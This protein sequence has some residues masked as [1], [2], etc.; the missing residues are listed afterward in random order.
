MTAL[1]T[2]VWT[3]GSGCSSLA[4][5]LGRSRARKAEGDL[6][7]ACIDAKAD[8]L[9]ARSL[10]S[11]D[12]IDIA[13]PHHFDPENVTE[14]VAAVAGGPHSSLAARVAS[15]LAANLGVPG[16][17][18]TAS[19]TPE[20]DARA[21]S[22]LAAIASSD[23]D[24]PRRLLRAPNAKALVESFSEGTLLVL[25]TPG[26]SWLQR[27]FF[28]P[29]RKLLYSA[30]A[31][32]VIV[33]SAPQRCF[34]VAKQANPFGIHMKAEDA[35]R[36]VGDDESTPVADEGILVGVIRRSVLLEGPGEATV[37]DLMEAPV[38]LQVDD[39]VTDLPEIREFLGGGS[40]PVID[41]SGA[42]FG[43]IRSD[44][45]PGTA[46]PKSFRPRDNGDEENPAQ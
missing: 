4:D 44:F 16:S 1:P 5:S 22:V 14:I 20:D 36:L 13:V 27:Q 34:Q 33:R 39:S 30:P 21:D 23:Q 11:F 46:Y 19:P 8:L 17:I 41:R 6:R 10:T 28:G 25:G 29:G 12:L 37:G 18:V 24:L 2:V 7:S 3:R 31:G 32:A 26:G 43:V 15:L 42:L 45:T 9:V 38:A 35:A 40:V